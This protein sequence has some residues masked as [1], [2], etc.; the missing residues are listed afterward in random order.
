MVMLS[1]LGKRLCFEKSLP[2]WKLHY[3]VRNMVWLKRQQSG[4]TKAILTALAYALA[5][6]RFDGP[7]RLPLVF[8]ASL[9]GWRGK[10]GRIS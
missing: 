1:F 7:S 9:E 5:A 3:K 4:G 2:D 8:K 10:L 6:V